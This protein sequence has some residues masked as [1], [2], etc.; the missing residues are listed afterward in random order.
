[1]HELKRYLQEC[2]QRV[3]RNLKNILPSSKHEPHRLHEAMRYSV[4][5]G[6]KRLRSALIYAMGEAF[7][8]NI[9]VLDQ[10]CVA[11]EL[12]HAFSLVHDDL[13]AIDNDSLRRG[14]MSCHKKF[15]EATAIITGDALMALSFEVLSQLP[16]ISPAINL[17][18]IKILSLSIGSYGM[19][20]GEALDV[21]L[22]NKKISAQKILDIYKM[23]TSYLLCAGL[24]LGFL[25]TN[26]YDINILK[27]IKEF[28]INLGLAF[29]IH[30]DLL[31]II[32]DPKKLG[33]QL[34][35]DRSKPTYAKIVGIQNA[36][37]MQQKFFN[38]AIF[39]LKKLPIDST[40]LHMLSNYIVTREI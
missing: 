28:G 19:A 9:K 6:G 20:G 29:Q 4:L 22:N 16:T 14:K 7:G 8:A 11:I 23:K 10:C 40:H 15:D 21:A 2:Q 1:M 27:N 17:T 5:N 18:M 24:I 25:A 26:R 13:P 30:D 38:K 32:G 39:Y 36:K 33:K 37:K 34:D 31:G 35:I 12:V 3:N